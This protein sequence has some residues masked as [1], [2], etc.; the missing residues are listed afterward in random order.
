MHNKYKYINRR[1]DISVSVVT[2]LRDGQ[3]GFNSRQGIFLFATTSTHPHSYPIGTTGYYLKVKRT[4]SQANYS[5]SAE[6]RNALSYN[7][8]P[9]YDFMECCLVKHRGKFTLH[10]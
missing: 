3:Q 7:F 8:T 5:L 6:V 4:G 2:R 1:R 9:L 10:K